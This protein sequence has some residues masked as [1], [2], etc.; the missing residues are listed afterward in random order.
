MHILL[1]L[2]GRLLILLTM[3][4][5]CYDLYRHVQSGGPWLSNVGQFWSEMDSAS[6]SGAQAFFEPH[7]GMDLWFS[8]LG[9]PMILVIGA[10]GVVFL[11]T[12][13]ALRLRAR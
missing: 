7:V 5:G 11:L 6:L 9:V 4:F 12:G 1:Q 3:L 10:T 8:L 13:V 2:L